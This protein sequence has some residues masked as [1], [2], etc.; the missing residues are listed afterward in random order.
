MEINTEETAVRCEADCLWTG[1]RAAKEEQGRGM[2]FGSVLKYT[3]E[4][5][6]DF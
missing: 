4:K 2:L 5:L 3:L 6:F 1:V